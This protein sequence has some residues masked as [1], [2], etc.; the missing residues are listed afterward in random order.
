[1]KKM[2][3]KSKKIKK[4]WHIT[5]RKRQISVLIDKVL[6]FRYLQRLHGRFWGVA[7][8]VGMLLGFSICFAI[9]P[10]LRSWSTA[11]SDFGTDIRTAPYFCGAVF[12]GAYGLWRWRNYLRRTVKHARP[13]LG[14]LTLTIIGLYLVAL[15]PIAWKPVPYYLHLAGVT[16][17]GVSIVA[18]VIIDGMLS[19]TRRS[20]HV[21][22]WRLMRFVSFGAIVVGGWITLGSIEAI[23]WYYNSGLGELLMVGGYGLWIIIKTYHGDGGRT[24]LSRML[25]SFVLV[26]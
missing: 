11:F 7:G 12:F 1:M 15:M 22:F 21:I 20:K 18:T 14:L 6:L 26:D 5:L 24:T 13:I 4:Y 9:R 16:L 3:V 8:L 2:T 19:K 17:A 25:H 23:D 10:E